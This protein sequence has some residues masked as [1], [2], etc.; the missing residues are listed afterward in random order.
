MMLAVA[1][2]LYEEDLIDHEF[3]DAWV[4]AEG[5]EEWRAYCMGEG[6]DGIWTYDGFTVYTYKEGGSETVEAVQ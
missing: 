6:E 2:V 1:Q 4:D 3:V 5:F